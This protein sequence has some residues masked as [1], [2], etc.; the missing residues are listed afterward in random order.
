MARYVPSPLDPTIQAAQLGSAV[1]AFSLLFVW[2]YVVVPSARKKLSK[3]KRKGTPLL[4]P[5]DFCFQEQCFNV[6]A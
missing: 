3:D 2:W 5:V 4:L 1:A 6:V